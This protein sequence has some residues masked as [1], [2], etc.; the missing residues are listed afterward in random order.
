VKTS[1]EITAARETGLLGKV[2]VLLI[3]KGFKITRQTVTDL[4]DGDACLMS[5]E[6]NSQQDVTPADIDRIKSEFPGIVLVKIKSDTGFDARALLDEYGPRLIKQYP[7]IHDSLSKCTAG[8]PESGKLEVLTKL[9]KG[10]GRWR[11]KQDYAR[12]GLLSFDKTVQR[13]LWPSLEDFLDI[14][15][16]GNRVNVK[17]CPVCA[18]HADGGK[19][20]HFIAAYIEGFLGELSHLSN[21][22]VVQSAAAAAGSPHCSFEVRG[23]G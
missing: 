16:D 2:A 9:G 15:S 18:S 22:S 1:I 13:M 4:D 19:N 3:K 10:L 14:E 8:L 17:D 11:Y 20:C 7:G 21:T 12:G 23:E 5:I 6:I